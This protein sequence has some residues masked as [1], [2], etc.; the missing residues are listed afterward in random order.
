VL[1]VT[2][3]VIVSELYGEDLL[4]FLDRREREKQALTTEEKRCLQND[5]LNIL[6]RL[7]GLGLS[8]LDFTPENVLI[9]SQGLRLCDFAKATPL[10]SP[11]FR[12]VQI[13]AAGNRLF[14]FESCEPTVGKGAYMPPECWKVY[15]KLEDTK[16][17]YPLEDLWSL[18]RPEDRSA[19]YFRVAEADVYMAGVLMFWIWAEGGI[20][21]CSDPKQDE[22]YNH[23][24]KS[25]LNFDLFKECRSWPK[26]LKDMLREALSPEPWR[27]L[28]LDKLLAHSWF[29]KANLSGSN[30]MRRFATG[31]PRPV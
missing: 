12:H 9:G 7:H 3:V 25:G 13:S 24:V 26:A 11:N 15:W 2:H 16:V 20:W 6:R 22:K 28:T 21:K 14:P 8:H 10:F 27:R 4:D 23:L 19:Y 17:K 18:H 29:S 30:F 5:T 31:G 1:E